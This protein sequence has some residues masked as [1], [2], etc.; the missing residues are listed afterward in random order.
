M[1]GF[2]A[3]CNQSIVSA[4]IVQT[5]LYHGTSAHNESTAQTMKLLPETNCRMSLYTMPIVTH[6]IKR[7]SYREAA[8]DFHILSVRKFPRREGGAGYPL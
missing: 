5:M 8:R 7:C 2:F 6:Q 1:T 3:E 4:A